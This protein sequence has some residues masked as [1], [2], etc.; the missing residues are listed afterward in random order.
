MRKFECPHCGFIKVLAN[1][2]LRK[3]RKRLS[4]FTC[5]NC[6]KKVSPFDL[7]KKR[8]KG[9]KPPG[10]RRKRVKEEVVKEI[11]KAVVPQPYVEQFDWKTRGSP[12]PG[13]H[14]RYAVRAGWHPK[15][16]QATDRTLE[17]V[18]VEAFLS[19]AP[20]DKSTRAHNL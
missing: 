5:T 19:R 8:G 6:G 9:P 3:F 14:R 18:V 12:P 15:P 20:K 13:E 7:A 4:G 16:L 2:E 17:E 1:R 11:P 10:E